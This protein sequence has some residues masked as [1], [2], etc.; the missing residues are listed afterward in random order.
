MQYADVFKFLRRLSPPRARIRA[1]RGST[2]ALVLFGACLVSAS[3]AQATP[4]VFSTT[5]SSQT[6]SGRYRGMGAP[7][8]EG[9]VLIAGGNDDIFGQNL[10]TAEVFDAT[11]ESFTLLT[12]PGS[13]LPVGVEAGVAAPLPGGDVLIA[14][15][16]SRSVGVVGSASVFDSSTDQ[17]TVLGAG[18]EMQ[19]ARMEA[20]AA[21][22]PNGEVLIAGGLTGGPTAVAS[23]ELFDPSTDTFTP[24]TG[25]GRQMT[26]PRRE[27]VASPLPNGEVLIAGGRESS[28]F[29]T[30]AE[31]FDPTTDTFKALELSHTHMVQQRSMPSAG[32]LASGQVLITGGGQLSAEVFD[33]VSDTFYSLAASGG[34]LGQAF[35]GDLMVP[36]AGGNSALVT[37][38]AIGF[39]EFSTSAEMLDVAPATAQVVGGEFGAQ[40]VGRPAGTQTLTVSSAGI[41]PLSIGSVTLD[42]ADA[43][44]FSVKADYCE[45]ETLFL[46]QTC[47]VSVG[48]IPTAAGLRTAQVT[49]RNAGTPVAT[50]PLTGTGFATESVSGAAPGSAST[51]LVNVSASAKTRTAS[52]AKPKR[53]WT[54]S[55]QIVGRS[56]KSTQAIKVCGLSRL[57]GTS[58]AKLTRRGRLLAS[59]AAKAV[60]G[61]LMLRLR[62]RHGIRAGY[63]ALTLRSGHGWTA[64]VVR[65]VVK[66]S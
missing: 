56:P 44:D 55:I 1:W 37:G 3:V 28:T 52:S 54:F 32:L 8:P 62:Q 38:G 50:V 42:G 27:A 10:T 23:A 22:L 14:G 36:L 4:P 25:A 16:D 61:T 11:T 12:G 39:N 15:G 66:L 58:R 18:H 49:L 41:L 24:L 53:C 5:L 13:E 34:T 20:V 17:F 6:A 51:A 59:S 46:K 57:P 2:C 40:A 26:T 64:H 31:L 65:L 7:L 45:G 29:L 48:F 9:K 60:H 19:V 47:T 33:P 30:S 21:P 43:E 63:Y 35:E